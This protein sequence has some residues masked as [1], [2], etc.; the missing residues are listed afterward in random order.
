VSEDI[1]LLDVRHVLSLQ[2]ERDD[3]QSGG[4]VPDLCAVVVIVLGP[5][6]L[7]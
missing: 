5:V 1:R 4:L 6:H 2:V 3:S 7:Q